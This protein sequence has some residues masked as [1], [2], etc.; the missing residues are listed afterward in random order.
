[1]YRRNSLTRTFSGRLFERRGR[2]S[3]VDDFFYDGVLETCTI[4]TVVIY[5]FLDTICLEFLNAFR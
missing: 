2:R 1:M 3:C 4:K 5:R